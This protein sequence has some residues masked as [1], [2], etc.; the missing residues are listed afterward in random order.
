MINPVW[1]NFLVIHMA[2]ICIR[3][4]VLVIRVMLLILYGGVRDADF[5]VQAIILAK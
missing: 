2:I 1:T 5:N 4:Q 3:Y